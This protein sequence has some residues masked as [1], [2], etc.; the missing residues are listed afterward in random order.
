I[1]GKAIIQIHHQIVEAEIKRQIADKELAHHKM[2]VV[3]VEVIETYLLTKKVTNQELY[4]WMRD[5]LRMLYKSS[6]DLACILAL[7]AEKAYQ[8][9]IGDELTNFIQSRITYQ[10]SQNES[11]LAGEQLHLALRQMERSYLE[12]N[13]RELELIK[14]IS[15]AQWNPLA[16]VT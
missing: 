4:A 9:E 2:Q 1:A 6:M 8:Y 15:L 10:D 14:H 3:Q 13:K 16:L 7:Q 12:T 5:R 11:L